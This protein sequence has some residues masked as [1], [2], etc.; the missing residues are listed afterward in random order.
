M[1]TTMKLQLSGKPT[2]SPK[3]GYSYWVQNYYDA[4]GKRLT[5]TGKTSEEARKK[6]LIKIDMA[7]NNTPML[8]KKGTTF[9]EFVELFLERSAV[10]RDGE[11][12][13]G[14]ETLKSYRGLMQ[15]WVLPIIGKKE[16]RTLNRHDMDRL[17]NHVI[18]STNT[19]A[20]AQ[21]VITITKVIL[22]YAV[23]AEVISVNPGIYMKVTTNWSEDESKK[24]DRIPTLDEM[25]RVDRAAAAGYTS[26]DKRIRAAYRRYYPLY[27]LVRLAG[28]RWSECAGLRW[29]D[30]NE[31]LSMVYIHRK[32]DRPRRGQTQEERIGKPKSKNSR[33]GVPLPTD[34]R[35]ILEAWKLECPD[36]TGWVFQTSEGSALNYSNV[37]SRFWIPLLA[38]AGVPH[39]GIHSLRHFYASILLRNNKVKEASEFLGHHSVAFTLDQYAHLIPKDWEV[40]DEA[41]KTLSA[42]FVS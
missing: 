26:S 24:E 11:L 39:M 22:N 27:I 14:R 2:V 35:P 10:G 13:L 9:G 38:R 20:T 25:A 15:K 21:K 5:A 23:R 1:A 8:P 34:V 33:R 18:A 41:R 40:I 30:F 12:P 37:R 36:K 7:M 3:N 28:I 6:A 4:T 29:T 42:N 19:R 16:L 32:V 31:D 17:Q